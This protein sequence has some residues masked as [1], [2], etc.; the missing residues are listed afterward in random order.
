ML[1]KALVQCRTLLELTLRPAVDRLSLAQTNDNVQLL[2]AR[3]PAMQVKRPAKDVLLFV[4]TQEHL[5]VGWRLCCIGPG[6]R[7]IREIRIVL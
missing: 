2:R 6:G 7:L 1:Q 3:T 4:R 5:R